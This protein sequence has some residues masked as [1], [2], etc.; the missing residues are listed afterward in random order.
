[1]LQPFGQPLGLELEPQRL[2]SR[3]VGPQLLESSAVAREAPIRDHDAIKRTFLRAVSRESNRYSHDKFLLLSPSGGNQPAKPCGMPRPVNFAMRFII[4]FV[5]SNCL[6]KRF[7]S[8][9]VVPLPAAMR[10][11]RLPFSTV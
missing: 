3:V 10:R 9:T 4:F 2:L 7:T 1:M 5:C 6:R 8:A 11:R